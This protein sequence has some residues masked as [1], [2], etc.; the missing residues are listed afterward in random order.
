MTASMRSRLTQG[1]KV[2]RMNA[3]TARIEAGA[4]SLPRRVPWLEELKR[5]LLAFSNG[6]YDD[7]VDAHRRSSAPSSA[8]HPSPSDS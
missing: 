5:E 7:Q 3:E 1:D 8:A 6:R 2:M 4:V